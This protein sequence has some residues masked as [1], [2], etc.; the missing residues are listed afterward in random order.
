MDCAL[1]I[2]QLH[3]KVDIL[4]IVSAPAEPQSCRSPPHGFRVY[5]YSYPPTCKD[6]FDPTLNESSIIIPQSNH[7]INQSMMYCVDLFGWPEKELDGILTRSDFGI[8][9][10][11]TGGFGFYL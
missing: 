1:V 5:L 2:I 8:I 4:A 10:Y 3:N 7:F 9:F 11:R 6:S